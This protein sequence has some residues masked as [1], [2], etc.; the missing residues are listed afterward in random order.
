[1][2]KYW[3]TVE[4]NG[5]VWGAEK[6]EGVNEKNAMTAAYEKVASHIRE[7]GQIIAL[8]GG[9]EWA[10]EYAENPQIRVIAIRRDRKQ[11]AA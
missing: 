9:P 11:V 10:A 3:V 6:C 4:V 7:C 5:N 1:M 2:I 8:S